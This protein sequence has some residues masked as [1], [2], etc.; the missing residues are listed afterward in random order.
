[1]K[2]VSGEGGD[3]FL[4]KVRHGNMLREIISNKYNKYKKYIT[5]IIYKFFVKELFLKPF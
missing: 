1:V 5:E 3:L 4:Y 2:A